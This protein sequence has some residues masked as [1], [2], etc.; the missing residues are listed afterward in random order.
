MGKISRKKNREDKREEIVTLLTSLYNQIR[1]YK[2]PNGTVK[3]VLTRLLLYFTGEIISN[4]KRK[5]DD[6]DSNN[7]NNNNSSSSSSSSSYQMLEDNNNN[8]NHN[9]NRSSCSCRAIYTLSS[10]QNAMR[11]FCEEQNIG[12][13]EDE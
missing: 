12:V 11:M 4:P 9:S 2:L 10:A 8:N 13:E 7:N 1:V 6:D 3:R 5:R